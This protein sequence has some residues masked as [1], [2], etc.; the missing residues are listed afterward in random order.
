MRVM[1]NLISLDM[2][3]IKVLMI[4]LL[5]DSR[6][7]TVNNQYPGQSRDNNVKKF[8]PLGPDDQRKICVRVVAVFDICCLIVQIHGQIGL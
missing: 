5:S 4:I 7:N 1:Y 2:V 3:L 8:N 6:K